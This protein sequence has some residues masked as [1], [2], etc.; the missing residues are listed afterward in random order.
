MGKTAARGVWL[1]V[2]SRNIMKVTKWRCMRWAWHVEWW[3]R[4]GVWWGKEASC[5]T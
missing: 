1:S 5:K 4:E 2:L 3:R